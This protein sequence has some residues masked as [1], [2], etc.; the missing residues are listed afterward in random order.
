M[1]TEAPE[2]YR[3]LEQPVTITV[4]W[5]EDV[6]QAAVDEKTVTSKDKDDQVYVVENPAGNDQVHVE[7][8]NTK[9]PGFS[10][11]TGDGASIW[12]PIA[13]AAGAITAVLA[14]VRKRGK[15]R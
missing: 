9:T 13:A 12:L 14:I 6:L 10:L 8:Y 1:E 3:L 11:K 5:T 7:I 2:G 15:S 4:T